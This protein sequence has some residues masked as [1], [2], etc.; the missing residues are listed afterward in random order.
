[1]VVE[2]CTLMDFVHCKVEV[3]FHILSPRV[4]GQKWKFLL[5]ALKVSTLLSPKNPHAPKI[6]KNLGHVILVCD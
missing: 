6:A 5:R 4:Q 2:P 1:M 3:I